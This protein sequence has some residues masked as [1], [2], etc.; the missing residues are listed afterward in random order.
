MAYSEA[1]LHRARERLL[2][3]KNLYEAETAARRAQVLQAYPRLREIDQALRQS[4]AGAVAA[5]FRKGEDTTAAIA[6]LKEKNLALQREREWI[7]ASAELDESVLDPPPFCP[8]CG[9]SGY[10]G[11]SM[12]EC[13]RELCRQEQK[14]ELSSLLGGKES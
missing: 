8:H 4:V 7:L 14:K 13:L 12:C 2:Q 11:S 9:G 3:E 5:A 10:V 1:V 6:A